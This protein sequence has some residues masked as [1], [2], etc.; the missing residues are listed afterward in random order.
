LLMMS[1]TW[2][3]AWPGIAP[4]TVASANAIAEARRMVDLPQPQCTEPSSTGGRFK[5]GTA[6][7]KANLKMD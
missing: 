7:R 4:R 5:A 6:I 1:A 3:W 2:V